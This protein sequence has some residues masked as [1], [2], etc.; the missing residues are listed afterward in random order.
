MQRHYPVDAGGRHRA[1]HGSLVE[2]ARSRGY[3]DALLSNAPLGFHGNGEWL[4]RLGFA[5][6]EGGEARYY[7]SQPRYSFDSP[8]DEALFA[9]ALEVL[10]S[11]RDRPLLLVLLTVSLH[12]PFRTPEAVEGTRPLGSALRYVDRTTHDFH[13]RLERSGY[14]DSGHL[15]VVGDHRRMT[16]LEPLER[17]ELGLDSLGRVFGCL[18]G[19]GVPPGTYVRT[20]LNQTDVHRLAGELIGGSFD[21]SRG[22]ERFNKGRRYRLGSLF[23]T[24]LMSGDRGLVRVRPVGGDPFTVRIA[25]SRDPLAAAPGEVERRLAAYVVLRTGLLERRQ[26]EADP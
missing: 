17:R 16:P 22:F 1:L 21:A 6:V 25:A 19:P 23:T 26:E 24:H 20:P 15:L 14:F 10:E 18:V 2:L 7:A 11:E 13:E 9:R 8:P 3:D 12:G 4:R 5:R